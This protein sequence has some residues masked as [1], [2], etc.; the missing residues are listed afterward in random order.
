MRNFQ[1]S[2]QHCRLAAETNT[3]G[4]HHTQKTSS[5]VRLSPMEGFRSDHLPHV[6]ITCVD[7]GLL[8][9]FGT[10]SDRK[11]PKNWLVNAQ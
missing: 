9:S 4:P 11:G 3:L 1:S 6:H 8:S 5:D 10:G 2:D 7:E